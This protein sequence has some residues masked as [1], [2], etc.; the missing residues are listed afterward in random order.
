MLKKP[1]CPYCGG[2]GEAYNGNPADPEA[3][4]GDCTA[5]DGTGRKETMM[6]K[7]EF[8]GGN[9]EVNEVNEKGEKTND[10]AM[11]GFCP[12]CEAIAKKIADALNEAGELEE[13]KN[14]IR[15]A[16]SL[17][18]LW[19][20]VGPSE[21][22]SK[23]AEERLKKMESMQDIDSPQDRKLVALQYEFESKYF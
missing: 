22:E 14:E 15:N 16:T 23:A 6:Y 8:L 21:E 7:A 1:I 10:L 18:S 3:Y 17:V 5:C 20:S 9:W 13:L 2:S 4:A 12:Q 11:V 19:K